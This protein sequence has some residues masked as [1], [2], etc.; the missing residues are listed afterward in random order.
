MH[1]S[2]MGR[3]TG[4]LLWPLLLGG[5]AAGAGGAASYPDTTK[6]AHAAP[7]PAA[8][9][10]RQRPELI[11]I[12]QLAG[13]SSEGE[14]GLPGGS[15]L[16]EPA[17]GEPEGDDPTAPCPA[18]M[19]LVGDRVCVDR[20]E[21]SLIELLPD[22]GER[23]WSPYHKLDGRGARLRAVSR[24]GVVPQGYISGIQA[25]E[26]CQAAAKRLCA[27]DEWEAACRGPELTTY[28]YGDRRQGG[29]C[30]DGGRARHPVAEA[31]QRL[32]LPEDRMWYEGMDQ[33]L[34]NQLEGTLRKTGE[35]KGC[36]NAF[37]VFDMVGNL[38]E[39]I[40]DPDGTFRGG[41]Y[42]DTKI[43]GEGCDYQ[44][45]AH[46]RDYHDY[47]TGFRCCLDAR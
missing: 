34:I 17:G 28:P 9:V 26:A 20:W 38:H 14:A 36:T 10:D 4:W 37:G 22:G 29:V 5:C 7:T 43:N 12:N 35:L 41:F 11:G 15:G 13:E 32:G 47:S 46:G 42:M 6:P 23:P 25:A 31:T 19:A 33:P 24:P 18:E 16:A 27:A 45:T 2:S 8:E 40:D 1:A 21:A 30:N 44:T 3:A 39:W